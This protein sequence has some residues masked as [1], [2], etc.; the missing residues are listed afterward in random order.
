MAAFT[1]VFG[2][3][4]LVYDEFNKLLYVIYFESDN[5][6][7]PIPHSASQFS[8]QFRRQFALRNEHGM[9]DSRQPQPEHWF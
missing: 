6:K 1:P 9:V 5:D 4:G 8:E 2:M 3:L 7:L